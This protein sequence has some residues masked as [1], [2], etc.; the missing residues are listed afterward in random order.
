MGDF[1]EPDFWL[2]VFYFYLLKDPYNDPVKVVFSM[3]LC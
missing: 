3:P 1:P 2:R